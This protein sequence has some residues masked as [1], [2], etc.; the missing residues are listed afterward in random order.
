MFIQFG[1]INS[2][3]TVAKKYATLLIEKRA[4]PGWLQTTGKRDSWATGKRIG[5]RYVADT[6]CW[7]TVR[8]QSSAQ[9]FALRATA[10]L[11]P[12]CIHWID[13]SSTAGRDDG[14][15]GSRC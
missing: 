7:S 15:Y 2:L 8:T 11:H 6:F 5:V 14:C 9:R 12:Q 4:S 1:G 10:L 13:G 3:I